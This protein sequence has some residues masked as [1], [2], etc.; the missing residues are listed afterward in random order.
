MKIRMLAALSMAAILLTV[1]CGGTPETTTAP[2]ATTEAAA[3]AET[4][5]AAAPAETT[6]AAAPAADAE[7]VVTI[8]GSRVTKDYEGN[9][10]LVVDYTFTNNSEETTSFMLAAHSKAFQDGV[11]LEVAMI[12]DDANFSVENGMKDLRPG[13]SL[14]IQEAFVLTSESDVELEVEEF[15]SM[16]GTMLATAVLPAK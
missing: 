10:A 1:G 16:D 11:Q 6:E 7:F 15:L 14:A 12:M 13:T 8:D 5:E 3:P 2:A 9:P 4:S